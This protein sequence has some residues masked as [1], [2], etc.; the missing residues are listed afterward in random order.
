M[1][2]RRK[3]TFAAAGAMLAPFL[4]VIPTGTASAHGYVS[5]PPSRQAQ[6][7]EDT[8]PCGP[9]KWEPQS[10]EGPKGLKSCNGGNES[11]AELN[12]DSK[13]WAVTPVGTSVDFHWSI[14]ARHASTTWE[15]YIGDQQVASFDD[16]GAKPPAEFDHTVDLSG[17]SGPQKVLAVW[18]VADTDNAFYACMDVNV[19]AKK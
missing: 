18:N 7:A 19:G 9:I 11:F 2:V 6:C 17:F 8:V 3:F 13:N 12:D 10:V 16:G 4:V 1:N 15:Y 5:S 14:T